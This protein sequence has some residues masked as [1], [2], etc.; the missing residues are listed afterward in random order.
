MHEL[1]WDLYMCPNFSSYEHTSQIG[2]ES[3]LMASFNLIIPSKERSACVLS[4]FSREHLF[5]TPWTVT[6]QVPLS[7][8]FSRLEYWRS[9]PFPSPGDFP[10]PGIEPTLLMSPAL[11]GTFFTTSA[12]EEAHLIKDPV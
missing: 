8:G 1:P 3:K 4:H 9:L 12:T 2:L 6:H 10:D 5:W 11:A 7:M